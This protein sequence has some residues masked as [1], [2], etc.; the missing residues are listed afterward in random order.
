MNA[1]NHSRRA[2][3]AA[4]IIGMLPFG[5]CAWWD[6]T[7]RHNIE[8]AISRASRAIAVANTEE[9]GR[10]AASELAIAQEKLDAAR[11]A[12][13]AQE[14]VAADRLISES[15]V[16]IQLATAKADAARVQAE[17][18]RR[19]ASLPPADAGNQAP[20]GAANQRPAQE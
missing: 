13:R 4:V 18:E 9:A 11:Q 1:T 12:A 14:Y 8:T 20:E 6:G 19:K 7:E 17:L 3:L 15:L 16:N 5:G 2:V 10:Y